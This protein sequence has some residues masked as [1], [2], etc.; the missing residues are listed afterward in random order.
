MTRDM[1]YRRCNILAVVL[2]AL[3]ALGSVSTL[4][5]APPPIWTS[6][7]VPAAILQTRSR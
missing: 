4:S 2:A 3:A 1:N 6:I 7:D 5:A